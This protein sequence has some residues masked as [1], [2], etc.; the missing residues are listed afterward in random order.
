VRSIGKLCPET[1]E[2]MKIGHILDGSVGILT[3]RGTKLNPPG[4]AYR[5][6]EITGAVYC[7][8][9]RIDEYRYPPGPISIMTDHDLVGSPASRTLQNL[10]KHIDSL[11]QDVW[12]CHVD[13]MS[14][15]LA[16]TPTFV[17]HTAIGTFNANATPRCS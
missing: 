4:R 16:K 8:L 7:I 12:R 2:T 9:R 10:D 17:T 15:S 13:L 1:F 3:S 11:L 14:M 5:G 6:T